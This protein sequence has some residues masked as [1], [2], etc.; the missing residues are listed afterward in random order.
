MFHPRQGA[1]ISRVDKTEDPCFHG[2][3]SL[4]KEVDKQNHKETKKKSMMNYRLCYEGNTQSAEE[5]RRKMRGDGQGPVCRGRSAFPGK[6]SISGKLTVHSRKSGSL[7][8][9]AQLVP[10]SLFVALLWC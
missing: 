2:I 5:R 7:S 9:G 1:K 4:V 8:L 6:D 10:H 3:Y